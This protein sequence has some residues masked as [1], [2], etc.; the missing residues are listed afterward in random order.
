ME[1]KVG[2]KAPQFKLV[3]QDGK[4]HSLDDLKGKTTLIYFYPK[5]ETPGCTMQACSLRDNFEELQA[6]GM[7]VVG[8]SKDDVKSHD[9]FKTKHNL[10]FDILADPE[11]AMIEAY[12]AWQERS[13]YGRK[14]FGTQRSAVI[15]GPDL[16][17]EAVWPKIQPLKTVPEALKWLENQN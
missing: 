3:D 6:K 1:L 4:T 8:V 11:H 17:I 9:K 5:D 13:M 15:V 7:D 10:P 2:D 12:G 14:F 16:M